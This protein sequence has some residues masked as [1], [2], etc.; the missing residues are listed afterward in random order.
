MLGHRRAAFVSVFSVYSLYFLLTSQ[1]PCLT[2]SSPFTAPGDFLSFIYLG[3]C[4]QLISFI[5]PSP[6]VLDTGPSVPILLIIYSPNVPQ[7]LLCV[8]TAPAV[9]WFLKVK[10]SSPL[11]SRGWNSAE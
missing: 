8:S 1:N 9:P 6:L 11:S 10:E 2:V 4:Y 7:P 3:R 5:S